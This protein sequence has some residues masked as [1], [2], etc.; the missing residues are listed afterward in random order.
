M[1]ETE[2]LLKRFAFKKPRNESR[3]AGT[4]RC[5]L[6]SIRD[7][8]GDLCYGCPR[9]DVEPIDKKSCAVA[10]LEWLKE[11]GVLVD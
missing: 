3:E 9:M 6:Q 1:D 2:K 5:L 11:I 4:L 8:H 7:G 10:C